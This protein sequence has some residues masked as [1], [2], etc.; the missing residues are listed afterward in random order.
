[1]SQCDSIISYFLEGGTLT[2]LQARKLCGCTNL[3]ACVR[4][5][6][7]RG[8]NI[9]SEKIRTRGRNSRSRYSLA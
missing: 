8:Y 4:I 1:M 7:G 9:N 2:N 6:K 3:S 5:L